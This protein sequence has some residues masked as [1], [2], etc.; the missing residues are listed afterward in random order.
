VWERVEMVNDE[1]EGER[2]REE[3]LTRRNLDWCRWGLRRASSLL[4]REWTLL[5]WCFVLVLV[6]VLVRV[7]RARLVEQRGSYS[8]S[9]R[10]SFIYFVRGGWWEFR[11]RRCLE[12]GGI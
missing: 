9:G 3:G 7:R 5:L 11:S 1:M 8:K 12:E 2:E 10:I 4:L 6:L